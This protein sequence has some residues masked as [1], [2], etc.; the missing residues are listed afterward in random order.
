MDEVE[1]AGRER[2][3]WRGVE[4]GRGR[5]KEGVVGSVRGK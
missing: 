1:S 3:G 2:E 4:E 5:G